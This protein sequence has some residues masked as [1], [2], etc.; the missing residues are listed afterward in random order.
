MS[1]LDMLVALESIRFPALNL[2]FTGITYLGAE[3]AYF[4]VFVVVY[5]CINRRLGFRLF[6]AFVVSAYAMAVCKELWAIPRPFLAYPHLLHP[7]ALST[8]EGYS[9]PSG[10]ALLSTVVWGYIAL[11]LRSWRWRLIPIATIVLV[12]FS[13]LY[14][15]LHWP[16]DII[17]GLAVGVVL[18]GAYVKVTGW[19][20]T[21]QLKLSSME[22]V[23]V[24][25]VT[26][27]LMYI[28]GV[29]V[30]NGVPA[31]GALMGGGLGYLALRHLGTYKE[32]ASLAGHLLKVI[33]SVALLL[34]GRYVLGRIIGATPPAQM[35]IY[36]SMA[37]TVTLIIPLI[38]QRLS[39]VR[40][41]Q[42]ET[43]Q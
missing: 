32:E 41:Q 35:L 13:R 16:A 26:G 12:S 14:L 31:A 22:C 11:Q 7:L 3:E 17:V 38:I 23:A 27:A 2:F 34:A 19:V 29:D 28:F 20:D 43:A 33:P 5:L 8:A 30:Q 42:G 37:F 6:L 9:M 1:G 39:R 4:L 10:H 21:G 40:L 18:L 25:V 15:Q 36:T 24:I